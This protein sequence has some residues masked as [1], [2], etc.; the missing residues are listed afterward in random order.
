MN[1]KVSIGFNTDIRDYS[2]QLVIIARLANHIIRSHHHYESPYE[3]K[4]SEDLRISMPTSSKALHK[5]RNP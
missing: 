5:T 4:Y 3:E 2:Y 1:T